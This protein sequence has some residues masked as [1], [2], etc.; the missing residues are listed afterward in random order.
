MTGTTTAAHCP[1]GRPLKSPLTA[2][3]YGTGGGCR[4]S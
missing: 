3:S 1:G 4:Q 2:H